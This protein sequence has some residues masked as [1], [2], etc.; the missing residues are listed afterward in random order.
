[1]HNFTLD[2]Q[3]VWVICMRVIQVDRPGPPGCRG[4]RPNH[5]RHVFNPAGHIKTNETCSC[6]YY[7]KLKESE[8][9]TCQCRRV[10]LNH[11]E[12]K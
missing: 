3:K 2:S 5:E 10:G 4:A 6:C 7:F 8:L 12:G 11:A 1:M 9:A